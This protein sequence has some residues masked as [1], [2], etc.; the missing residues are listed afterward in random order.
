M[1]SGRSL[2]FGNAYFSLYADYLPWT[3]CARLE[4]AEKVGST[5]WIA[6]SAATLTAAYLLVMDATNT[7]CLVRA[8][9]PGGKRT[10]TLA[11]RRLV[12]VSGRVALAQGD[13]PGA[14]KIA[15]A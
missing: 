13:P 10:L 9:M 4:I 11:E 7:K 14:L 2:Y 15:E 8:W 1:D 12:Q 5:W 6:N 3:I